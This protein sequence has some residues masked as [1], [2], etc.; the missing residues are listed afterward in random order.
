[1]SM[2]HLLYFVSS[3]FALQMFRTK[4]NKSLTYIL[5]TQFAV[6]NIMVLESF[7]K[8]YQQKG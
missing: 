2:P 5:A 6:I 3:V 7:V 1:M 4:L 8:F